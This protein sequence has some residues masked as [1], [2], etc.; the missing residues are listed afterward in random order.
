MLLC[1]GR[2]VGIDLPAI[3]P[4]RQ[5][6]RRLLLHRR[7]TMTTRTTP[8]PSS[9]I[10]VRFRLRIKRGADIAVGPGKVDLLEAI[11]EQGSIT[12][13][14]KALGMSYRRAWLLLDEL[15]R[16]LR[17]PATTSSQGGPHGGGCAVTPAG[18]RLVSLYRDI[19]RQAQAACAAQLAALTQM[20]V[21]PQAAP[22]P[23]PAKLHAS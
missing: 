23:A 11:R 19:E 18:E 3:R 14:A 8:S 7:N 9:R 17:E 1:G 22:P 10:D 2:L 6:H 4:T 13:A 5:S 21:E 15:N 16:S 12:Q 20:V